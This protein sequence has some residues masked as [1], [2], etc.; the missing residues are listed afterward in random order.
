MAKITLL[1][2]LPNLNSKRKSKKE[3]NKKDNTNTET[4]LK[5]LQSAAVH[6]YYENT[7]VTERI[8]SFWF[9]L[10]EVK[11]VTNKTY[12]QNINSPILFTEV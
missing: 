8:K 12:S 10:N 4:I 1:K 5:S 7:E 2:N 3:V 6:C 9:I 11:K